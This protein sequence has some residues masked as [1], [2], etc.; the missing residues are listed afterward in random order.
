MNHEKMH[1]DVE[2]VL[3]SHG[4]VDVEYYYQKARE[5]Q[6]AAMKELMSSIRAGISHR[7]H[8]FYEKYLC[9]S[10]SSAH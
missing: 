9:M 1:E 3:D 4:Q 5:M 2:I 7:L 8:A 10:C 6:T